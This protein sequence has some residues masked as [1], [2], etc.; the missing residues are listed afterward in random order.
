MTTAEKLG[1]DRVLDPSLGHQSDHSKP[2]RDDKIRTQNVAIREED[3]A[4][5]IMVHTLHHYG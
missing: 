3:F 1:C 2:S 4:F 5:T